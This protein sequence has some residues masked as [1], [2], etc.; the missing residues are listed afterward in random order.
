MIMVVEGYPVGVFALTDLEIEE[1]QSHYLK[2]ILSYTDNDITV[3]RD[4]AMRITVSKYGDENPPGFF[5][6]FEET[7]QKYVDEYVN[8]FRFRFP[9]DV[10]YVESWYNVH[11]KYDHQCVHDH[12]DKND[13]P[14]FACNFILKQPNDKSGQ[15]TFMTPNLSNHLKYLQLDPYDDWPA[16]FHPEMKDGQLFI[17]P[18]CMQHYVQFNQTEESRVVMVTNIKVTRNL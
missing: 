14:T 12:L 16:V 9:H 17:F 5:K 8:H 3:E 11:N 15:L 4:S 13:V 6:K 10:K 7:I 18:T 2:K 1:L